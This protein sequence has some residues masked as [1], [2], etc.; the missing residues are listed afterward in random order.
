M[1]RHSLPDRNRTF[2][3]LILLGIGLS[4]GLACNDAVEPDN[5]VALVTVYP[6]SVALVFLGATVQLDATAYDINNNALADH[7]FTWKSADT[8]V[9]TVDSSG[10]VTAIALDTTTITATTHDVAGVAQVTVSQAVA[11][12]TL[13]PDT[14][15]MTRVGQ[16]RSIE[17]R[18]YDAGGV[19]ISGV[20]FTWES[21]DDQIATVTSVPK[22]GKRPAAGLVTVVAHGTTAVT[23]TADGLSWLQP[24]S[25]AASV[26]VSLFPRVDVTPASAVISGVGA[27]QPFAAGAWDADGNQIA[28]PTITW[29]SLNPTV[30][31]IDAITGEA[32]VAGSGQVT[33]AAEVD[34]TIGYALMTVSVPGMAPITSWS[35][36][37]SLSPLCPAP[38]TVWGTSSSDI[39]AGGGGGLLHSDGTSWTEVLDCF[40]VAFG[41]W[42]ASSS[43]VYAVG[44]VRI[45]HY[46]GTTWTETTFLGT[47]TSL[48]AVWGTSPRD[49]YAVGSFDPI[50]HYNGQSWGPMTELVFAGLVD[51]WGTLSSD[52]YA[53]GGLGDIFHYD[54][55]ELVQMI[56]GTR[57]Q[58]RGVW[59]TSSS[60]VYV[61]GYSG[62]I[63]H[64]DGSTWSAMASGTSEHLHGVWG[65]SSSDVYAV[66]EGG[67]ILRYDG[68]EW[69]ELVSGTYPD[70]FGIWGSS[71]GDVYVVGYGTI[72]R[73]SR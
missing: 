17:A 67:T 58:L 30:A 19:R 11:T 42:G 1:E 56:S 55:T 28:S 49:V 72:V 40:A 39:Y 12:I 31:T 14:V 54:G 3:I 24:V 57:R 71:S 10:L 51:V 37:T 18:A 45:Q 36:D 16:T 9:A 38:E 52:I 47:G 25:S 4:G 41:V 66:G 6:A 48:R 34:G 59:G 7:A 29:T 50:M 68:T 43:D 44:S 13:E 2:A 27:T 32:T 35:V 62:T 69:S 64:Y 70:L 8:S 5:V 20:P 60:D 15:T 65:T 33:I 63:L 21:S 73:G 46:D 22:L 53:V 26:T 23:A 61:V